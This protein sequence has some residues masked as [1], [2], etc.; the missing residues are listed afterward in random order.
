MIS[1]RH[2]VFSYAVLIS[3]IVF[4]SCYLILVRTVC[5]SSSCCSCVNPITLDLAQYL[6]PLL[7]KSYLRACAA[8]CCAVPTDIQ[9]TFFCHDCIHFLISTSVPH[10]PIIVSLF[11]VLLHQLVQGSFPNCSSHLCAFL[12]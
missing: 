4:F 9:L 5:F 7:K 8:S 2:K 11:S 6:N 10:V 3:F 12:I 1:C